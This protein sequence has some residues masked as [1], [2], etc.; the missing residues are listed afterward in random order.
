MNCGVAAISASVAARCSGEARFS[1]W[2]KLASTQ[3]AVKPS[4][5]RRL[6][7]AGP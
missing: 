3:C 7:G 1:L 5:I 2:R 4:S 6:N